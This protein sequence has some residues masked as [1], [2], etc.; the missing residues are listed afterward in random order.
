MLRGVGFMILNLVLCAF[1]G[2]C[3]CELSETP[4]DVTDTGPTPELAVEL[5]YQYYPAVDSSYNAFDRGYHRFEDKISALRSLMGAVCSKVGPDDFEWDEDLYYWP[6]HFQ[7]IWNN[8]RNSGVFYPYF[9]F[10]TRGMDYNGNDTLDY[11]FFVQTLLDQYCVPGDS[12]AFEVPE[13]IIMNYSGLDSAEI[14]YNNSNVWAR[15]MT[16]E[17][18]HLF[19]CLDDYVQAPRKHNYDT[20]CVMNYLQRDTTFAQ[21]LLNNIHFC[22]RCTSYINS[23]AR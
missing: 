23:A 15:N 9:M 1:L 17:L 22:V 13:F 8:A 5:S 6:S 14:W 7:Y 19:A 21:I 18:G 11:F 10:S 20:T 3:G 16:H 4:D 12:Q 2:I